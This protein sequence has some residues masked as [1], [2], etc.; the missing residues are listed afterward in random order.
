MRM[1]DLVADPILDVLD[2]LGSTLL[3][4]GQALGWLVRPPYRI[5]QLTLDVLQAGDARRFVLT[6]GAAWKLWQRPKP[7]ADYA[8]KNNPLI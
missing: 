8:V 7:L 6:R 4:F 2:D 1:V 3:L 5:A